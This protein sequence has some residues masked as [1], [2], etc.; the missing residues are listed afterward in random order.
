[1]FNKLW[2][3]LSSDD[4]TDRL[5]M[6]GVLVGF[7]VLVGVTVRYLSVTLLIALGV[8]TVGVV[9]VMLIMHRAEKKLQDE[10]REIIRSEDTGGEGYI[11]VR[12]EELE[13]APWERNAKGQG[14]DLP[15]IELK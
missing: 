13:A 12:P 4:K 1:M 5:I 14:L 10:W 9:I 2:D 7:L 3:F 6:R 11:N 8:L 15:D